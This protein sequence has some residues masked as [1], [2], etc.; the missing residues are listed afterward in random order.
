MLFFL[1]KPNLGLM[2][3]WQ[4]VFGCTVFGLL[5]QRSQSFITL[6]LVIA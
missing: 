4:V 1:F 6:R 5:F 3:S 2:A